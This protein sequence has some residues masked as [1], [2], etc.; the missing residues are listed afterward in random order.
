MSPELNHPKSPKREI[1]E[2][3]EKNIYIY[4]EK[5]CGFGAD[6]YGVVAR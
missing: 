2:K 3:I 1:L 4:R 5:N 6:F